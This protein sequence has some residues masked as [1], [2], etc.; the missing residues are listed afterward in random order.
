MPTGEIPQPANTL[1][2]EEETEDGITVLDA[3]H[4]GY[5]AHRVAI[6]GID[7]GLAFTKELVEPKIDG[8]T[9]YLHYDGLDGIC[10]GEVD[11]RMAGNSFNIYGQ[12]IR[13]NMGEEKA[14]YAERLMVGSMALL[15]LIIRKDF[16]DITD[17]EDSPEDGL[18]D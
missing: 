7:L 17:F 1:E 5:Q 11:V 9:Y 16:P 15:P 12:G 4:Q 2:T 14:D 8:W 3:I 13:E 6:D 10:F 18:E